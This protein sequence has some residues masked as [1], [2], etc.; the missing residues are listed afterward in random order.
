METINKLLKRQATKVNR[1][2]QRQLEDENAADEVAEA[3][4]PE[5]TEPPKLI[6]WVS[7]KNGSFVGVPQSWLDAPVGNVFKKQDIAWRRG[8][9]KVGLVEELPDEI[10][11][12]V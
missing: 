8:V 5:P 3:G 7:N 4:T 10:M 12:G 2:S 9:K 11:T 1:R 6:R